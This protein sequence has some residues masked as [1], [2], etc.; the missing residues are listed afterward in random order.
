MHTWHYHPPGTF[1]RTKHNQNFRGIQCCLVG[2]R[3]TQIYGIIT[4]ECRIKSPRPWKS[5]ML[6]KADGKGQVHPISRHESTEGEQ[7]Y[8]STPS[9]TSAIDDRR[10]LDNTSP[11]ALPPGMTRYRSYR[12]L[13]WPRSRSERVRKI[14]P[15]P[16]FDDQTV[17][18]VSSRKTDY[19]IPA[20]KERKTGR[21]T[22]GKYMCIN[23]INPY[24]NAWIWC[25]SYIY[26]L[27]SQ[28][29]SEPLS[30]LFYQMVLQLQ[31]KVSLLVSLKN[32]ILYFPS[33]TNSLYPTTAPSST[34]EIASFFYNL[35]IPY[36]PFHSVAC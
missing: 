12:K 18:C 23:D 24:T 33:L 7:R 17:Q 28:R 11:A 27:Q 6:Y 1:I 32:L 5:H 29:L 21:E 14:S 34:N 20:H 10:Q 3:P 2:R 9:L 36:H 4:L 8:T 15:L 19:A 35:T 31:E 26:F 30:L 16:G 22:F 25:K 13:G